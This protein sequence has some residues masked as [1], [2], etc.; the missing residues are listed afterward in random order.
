SAGQASSSTA[1]RLRWPL[2]D[3]LKDTAAL[4]Y[5]GPLSATEVKAALQLNLSDNARRALTGSHIGYLQYF[6]FL[7]H[8][9]QQTAMRRGPK[10][11]AVSD[12]T[13][14]R[15]QCRLCHTC[16]HVAPRHPSNL[17][18]HLFGG[19]RRSGCLDDRRSDPVE[20]V[21]PPDRD[22]NGGLVRLNA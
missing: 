7:G 11:Q 3:E 20:D 17:G 14:E 16:L 12:L 5:R 6:H 8:A 21:P 15:W 18:A 4:H 19:S 10:R 13:A 1:D 22:A 2:K 9:D